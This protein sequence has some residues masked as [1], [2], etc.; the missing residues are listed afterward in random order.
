MAVLYKELQ[1]MKKGI[2]KLLLILLIV[3]VV[4]AFLYYRNSNSRVN[5]SVAIFL[6]GFTLAFQLLQ[7]SIDS[8][9]G[10]NGFEKL[11]S[12]YSLGKI[13]FIKCCFAT[14]FGMIV[15]SVFSVGAYLV[16][17]FYSKNSTLSLVDCII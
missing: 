5:F 9:K 3:V 2:R 17:H 12:I 7:M 11:L 13:I 8:E 6:S 1:V 16:E 4:V 15:G 14:A 10:S